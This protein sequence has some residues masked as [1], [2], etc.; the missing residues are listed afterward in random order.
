L[1]SFPLTCRYVKSGI[2]FHQKAQRFNTPAIV[3]W[4]TRCGIVEQKTLSEWI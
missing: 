2:P 1:A 4:L 3:L